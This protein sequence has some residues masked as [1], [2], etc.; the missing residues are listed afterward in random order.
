[1]TESTRRSNAPF[2]VLLAIT[3]LPFLAAW[4]V[5]FNPSLLGDF[6]TSNRGMLVTP[7]RPVPELR[8]E[9]LDGA[10]FDT[11]S[12]RGNWTMLAVADSRCDQ[13]CETNL[14]DMR[15]IRLAMGDERKRIQRVLLLTDTDA[16]DRLSE[17]LAPFEGTVVVTGP[18]GAR[19]RL[20]ALL[21]TGDDVP[22]SDRVFLIDTLGNL[23]MAYPPVPP[24][25]D[26]LKDL[27]RLLKVVR[28]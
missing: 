9:T 4:V 3:G 2:W 24:A 6:S 5:Y 22:A 27:E 21:D 26:V 17:H 15:Q 23:M 13:G 12:L 14:Y 10:G 19:A 11:A 18:A 20:L 8:L 16:I 7:T 25:K 1:M 28:L